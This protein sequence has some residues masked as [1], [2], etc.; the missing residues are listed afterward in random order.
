MP[1]GP[2]GP[3]TAGYPPLARRS[4]VTG[5]A[6]KRLH[7]TADS[8]HRLPEAAECALTVDSPESWRPMRLCV[9]GLSGRGPRH[10][11]AAGG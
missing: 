3:L 5:M 6:E 8:R 2:Q 9:P 1:R 10:R 7:S 11:P 4:P